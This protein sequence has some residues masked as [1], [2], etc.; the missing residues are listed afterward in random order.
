[1]VACERRRGALTTAGI[2]DKAQVM[3]GRSISAYKVGRKGLIRVAST[4]TRNLQEKKKNKKE[5]K[6]AGSTRS[7][8][9]PL[10]GGSR[11]VICRT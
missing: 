3:L 4:R 10:T 6:S 1:M 2:S 8:P 11:S 9:H 7:Y 5:G